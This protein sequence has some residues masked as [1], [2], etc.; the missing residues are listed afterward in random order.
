M[1]LRLTPSVVTKDALLAAAIDEVIQG[2]H[3]DREHREGI[4]RLQAE[5]RRYLEDEGWSVFLKLEAEVGAC[6][7]DLTVTLTI[8]AFVQGHLDGGRGDGR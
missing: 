5:L 1:T 6:L 2:D 3:K 7:A 4:G 8:W